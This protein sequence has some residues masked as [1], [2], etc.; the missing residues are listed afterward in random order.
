[1]ESN[2]MS[3]FLMTSLAGAMGGV[4]QKV[5][6]ELKG[7]KMSTP[8]FLDKDFAE[9]IPIEPRQRFLSAYC[10]FAGTFGGVY[11]WVVLSIFG[12]GSL[13][14][15]SAQL[16][17][18]FVVGFVAHRIAEFLDSAP[19]AQLYAWIKRLLGK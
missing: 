6:Q 3:I 5:W 17:G 1:M 16:A 7:R 15:E 4:V 2:L 19:L 14:A 13:P 11:G 12:M 18:A 9:P 10:I 8:S